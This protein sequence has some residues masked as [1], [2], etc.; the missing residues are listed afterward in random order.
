MFYACL[1]GIWFLY[2][3]EWNRTWE[4]FQ[5]YLVF[6]VAGF[7]IFYLAL[8]EGDGRFIKFYKWHKNLNIWLGRLVVF[9]ILISWFVIMFLADHYFPFPH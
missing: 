2:I 6:M 8:D 3:D 5:S 1:F 9:I 4:N 7:S